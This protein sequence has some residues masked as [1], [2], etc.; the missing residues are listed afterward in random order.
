LGSLLRFG[1]AVE[2]TE[3]PLAILGGAFGQIPA[4]ITKCGGA[5][6]VGSVGLHEAS[7]EVVLANEQAE[8]VPETRLAIAIVV[9]VISVRGR[10]GLLRRDRR[11]RSRS[12]AK[13]LDRAKADAVGLAKG[14]IDGAS[15]GDAHF[16]A[17]D[18]GRDVGGIGVSV[19]YEA[20]RARGFVDGCS[21]HPTTGGGV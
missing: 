14:A 4:G 16:G 18:Q 12:A 7:I 8:A 1:I 15:F 11:V 6:V 3:Q 20:A 21:E 9:A 2:L 10:F 19:A 17:V 13:F 5:A